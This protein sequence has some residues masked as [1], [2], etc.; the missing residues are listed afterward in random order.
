MKNKI[1]NQILDKEEI[2]RPIIKNSI[3]AFIIGGLIC[4]F[5]ESLIMLFITNIWITQI[6][7]FF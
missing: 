2:K 6:A 3:V 5:G 1:Y 7:V 4:L